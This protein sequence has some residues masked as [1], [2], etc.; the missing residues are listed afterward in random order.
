[1]KNE[2]QTKIRQQQKVP[3]RTSQVTTGSAEK[4]PTAN[5]RHV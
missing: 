1:M 4:R 2:T 3:K 5:K